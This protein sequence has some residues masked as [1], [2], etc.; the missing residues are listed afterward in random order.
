MAIGTDPTKKAKQVLAPLLG[1]AL[2][3]YFAYHAVQGD[4]GL[5]AWWQL[6]Q[7][8]DAT[9]VELASINAERES[10]E[11]MISLLRPENLDSDM[12]DEQTRSVLAFARPSEYLIMPTDRTP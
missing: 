7:Q 11:D 5:L 3:T 12:L 6:R 1:A 4:R 9:E 2:V 10:L 8:M